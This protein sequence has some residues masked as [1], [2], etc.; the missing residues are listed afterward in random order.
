MSTSSFD[1]KKTILTFGPLRI[2]GFA[3]GTYIDL[4]MLG[5]GGSVVVGA[6]G[7]GVVVEDPNK[8]AECTFRLLATGIGRNMAV[9]LTAHYN[10]GNPFLPVVVSSLDTGEQIVSGAGKIKRL[11]NKPFAVGGAPVRE[12]V[13]VMPETLSA[14]VPGATGVGAPL[15]P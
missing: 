8:A 6:Y 13:L 9:A 2:L 7:D 12:W 5:A 1:P 3:E 11:P 10:G 15:A 14:V 4:A